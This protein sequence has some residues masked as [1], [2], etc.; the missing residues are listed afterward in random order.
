MKTKN[1]FSRKVKFRFQ[2]LSAAGRYHFFYF[3]TVIFFGSF[4]L[5]NLILAIVSRSYLEQQKQVQAELSQSK[6]SITI[7]NQ[8]NQ[9]SDKTQQQ[10]FPLL[11]YLKVYSCQWNCFSKIR[12]NVFSVYVNENLENGSFVFFSVS[13][14]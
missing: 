3:L 2:V 11:K 5:V 7:A 14:Q 6:P 1:K 9:I 4:Y 12:V 13:S 10:R 8:S